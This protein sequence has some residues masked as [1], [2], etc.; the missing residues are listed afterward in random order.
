M[1]P[2]VSLVA[3]LA[4]AGTARVV[5]EEAA[6]EVGAEE[7]RG[8]EPVLP[9]FLLNE[10]SLLLRSLF[11]SPALFLTVEI[12]SRGHAYTRTAKLTSRPS[13]TQMQ[14]RFLM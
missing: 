8:D 12:L 11:F 13:C 10:S 3:A 1:D 2:T 4:E 6:G 14:V 9:F 7:A 5:V